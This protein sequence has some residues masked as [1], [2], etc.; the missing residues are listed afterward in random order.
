M[1]SDTPALHGQAERVLS[2][3]KTIAILVLVQAIALFPFRFTGGMQERDSYRMLLGML[4][5]ITRGTYFASPL[6]YNREVSF[7]YYALI[8]GL[9]SLFGNSPAAL[10]AIMNAISFAAAVLFVIPFYLVVEELFDR[11]TAIAACTLLA[12]VPVWWNVALYGHP[13]MPAMLLL[14]SAMAVLARQRSTITPLHIRWLVVFTLGL[15]LT[16]RFDVTLLFPA[17][18]AVIWHR[19]PRIRA[20]AITFAFYSIGAILFFKLAQL[21]LPAVK[22]GPPPESILALLQRFEN[23]GQVSG[24]VKEAIREA[25][26]FM[27][28]GF[29]PLLVMLAIPA[30]LIVICRRNVAQILFVCVPILLTAI[31]SKHR[32]A[33]QL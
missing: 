7:G 25:I 29:T 30:F 24:N 17:L 8:Y 12:V 23:L 20:A 21:A 2:H 16:F 26:I 19:T 18:A 13:I 15:A 32:I 1:T 22:N 9:S 14:F 4:D 28:E 10:V 3:A 5:G 33:P 31:H 11:Y 27:G 6:L